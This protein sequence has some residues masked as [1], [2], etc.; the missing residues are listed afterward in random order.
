MTGYLTF[1]SIYFSK[2]RKHQN[3]NESIK[4]TCTRTYFN[5]SEL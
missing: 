4:E 1:F 3:K 5:E 2:F